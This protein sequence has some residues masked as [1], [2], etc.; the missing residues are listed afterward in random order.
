MDRTQFD[1]AMTK[2]RK[3]SNRLGIEV[4][5]DRYCDRHEIAQAGIQDCLVDEDR[6]LNHSVATVHDVSDQS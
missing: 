5:F 6:G 2:L 3:T 1:E 4:G